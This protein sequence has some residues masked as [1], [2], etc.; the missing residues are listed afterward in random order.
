MRRQILILAIFIFVLTSF[1][2]FEG[3]GDD[4]YLSTTATIIPNAD[5]VGKNEID[6]GKFTLLCYKESYDV[7]SSIDEEF[8]NVVYIKI[9]SIADFP[10][11]SVVKIPDS[12]VTISAYFSSV[13]NFYDKQN[14]TGTIKRVS[15]QKNIQ[16]IKLDLSYYDTKRK[17]RSLVKGQYQFKNDTDYFIRNKVEF[18]GVYDN[19]RI[20][21]KEPEMVK[22]LA[23][24]NNPLPATIGRFIN[25]E[26]LNLS[27]ADLTSLP[28][29]IGQVKNLRTLDLSYNDFESFPTE[30][31]SLEKLDSLNLAYC[32]L[33]AI[34]S[35]IS[36]LKNLKK[37]KID[38]NRLTSFPEAI[39]NLHSLTSLSIKGDSITVI[40]T[41][42]TKLTNLEKLDM[43]SFWSYIGS[44]RPENLEVLSGLKNLRELYFEFDHL[45]T[46]PEEFSKLEK[47]EILMI[48]FNDFKNFPS[49]ID[50]IPNL[51][52]L[53]ISHE[54]F[55]QA[56]MAELRLQKKK[57]KVRIDNM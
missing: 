37:L 8:E 26:N 19:L 1:R 6:T 22:T 23:I 54:E 31:L 52:L 12:K 32:H 9:K 5:L 55:D 40:P 56:T 41:E 20:A 24:N 4:K 34:P 50:K 18:N 46:L 15:S 16:S 21:L 10:I 27:S 35:Q 14:I 33:T 36:R 49:V 39:T 28:S 53:I 25:L 38:F 13:W 11:N 57:Y 7:P 48:K 3:N 47:L 43:S 45:T 51:K 44:N 29:E 17:T 42:I 2:V 30:I